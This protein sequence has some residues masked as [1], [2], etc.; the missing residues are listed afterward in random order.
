MKHNVKTV[1]RFLLL[2]LTLG[3]GFFALGQNNRG[4]TAARAE[5]EVVAPQKRT[6]TEADFA[7]E[8]PAD[9][10]ELDVSLI[11]STTTDTSQSLNFAFKSKTF[12]GYMASRYNDMVVNI[13]DPSYTGDTSAP[14]G[15]DFDN[16]D[17]ETG[18]PVFDGELLY[19]LGDTNKT[20]EVFI[21][22]TLTLSETFIVNI[23]TI[24]ANCVSNP[25]FYNGGAGNNS[26]YLEDGL[27]P[28]YNAIHIP[29]TVTTVHANA[30]T[31]VPDS[32]SITYEGDTI[33]TGFE[34][35]WAD[36]TNIV[37]NT[38]GKASEEKYKSRAVGGTVNDIVD[39]RGRPINFCLGCQPDDKK[40]VGEVYDRPLVIEF[41]VVD[42][43]NP[44][45][46]AIR[47]VFEEL[48]LTNTNG[49]AYDSV[50]PISNP[51]YSRLYGYKLASNEIIKIESITF[52]NIMKF[53]TG[54]EIK[55]EQR[56]SAKPTKLAPTL[57][58][59]NIVSFK[60]SSNSTFAG[61]SM[62]SFTMDKNLSI[63]SEKYPEPHSL[64]LDVKTDFYEQN[65]SKIEA[66]LT[67]IRYSLY[68]LYLSSYHFVYEG[69][70]G[71]LK[72][73]ILPISTAISYQTLDK[74]N[75]NKVSV[76][77][78]HNEVKKHGEEI[79]VDYSDFSASKVKTFEIMN[80]T[81][82]M[83]LL[84]TSDSGSKAMLAKS[85]ASYKFAYLTIINDEKI[86]VLNWNVILIG[87]LVT[88][89][90]IFTAGAFALYK[91]KKEKYK[92][93]EFKRV[94][95]KKYLKSSVLY[96]LGFMVIV[97]AITFIFMRASGFANT[98]VAFN[99]TDPLL[100]AFAIAGMIIG[101]YFIVLAIKA[102]KTE[103]E[104]KKAI[105]LKLNEDVEDDGTN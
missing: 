77:I 105:R 81:I 28:K 44:T 95:D 96:G 2:S 8:I 5:S 82:Q 76:I 22:S 26:S 89:I 74:D 7:D 39:D 41:D 13:S 93:D 63:T 59:S 11:Q 30:F 66:G 61:F 53:G 52:H 100:I 70:G 37:L 80:L 24:C 21:P 78:D 60:A 85:Q 6:F 87:L 12:V 19:I 90:A 10:E 46:A 55:T 40:Y 56:Y 91:Y 36:T 51:S 62:F 15:E 3:C 71:Q 35:G 49:S 16:F 33:P 65:R 86:K 14:V 43:A 104:R 84:T 38:Y 57:D 69:K 99:P 97:Y 32:V 45:G 50:G 25:A 64:Y 101:G 29:S 103:K 20:N 47:H 48:P 27:T 54:T 98:I 102:I 72:D 4:L 18:L 31:G 92:N 75:N 79:G 67:S 1:S 34:T 68:N 17:D 73:L 23:S 42:K 58:L 88:Y 94:N 83:D 9:P